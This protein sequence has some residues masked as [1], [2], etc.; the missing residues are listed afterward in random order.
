MLVC[1]WV[2]VSV[3]VLHS[4]SRC[5][6]FL[7]KEPPKSSTQTQTQTVI[8]RRVF[9]SVE[10][11]PVINAIS[12]FYERKEWEREEYVPFTQASSSH[13]WIV[14]TGY[15]VIYQTQGIQIHE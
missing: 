15:G 7:Q 10:S 12:Y 13:K 11:V 4:H 14:Y 8:E 1:G 5:V 2:S 6:N 9:C 3:G